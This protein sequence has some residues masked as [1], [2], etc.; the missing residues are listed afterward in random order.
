MKT[1]HT[2]KV[3]VS[4]FAFGCS[5]VNNNDVWMEFE[6]N[7]RQLTVHIMA[8]AIYMT[9]VDTLIKQDTLELMVYE[10]PVGFTFK[11]EKKKASR[12]IIINENIQFIK[13]KDK[14]YATD[15]LSKPK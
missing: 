10:K 9:K 15:S 8:S 7:T 14:V 2:L 1:L 11:E 6:G 4:L 5:Q 12:T 13:H 3:M